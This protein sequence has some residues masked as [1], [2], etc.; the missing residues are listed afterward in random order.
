MKAANLIVFVAAGIVANWIASSH[1][2]AT[3]PSFLLVAE[4][5]DEN[6]R[7]VEGATVE[8]NFLAEEPPTDYIQVLSGSD[9]RA[10]LQGRAYDLGFLKVEK[11][12]YYD[13]TR[14]GT[15]LLRRAQDPQGMDVWMANSEVFHVELKTK[16]NPTPMYVHS[17]RIR[18]PDG[19][20][21]QELG[22]DLVA[23]DWVWP[24]GEGRVPDFLM[25][26]TI[27]GDSPDAV[28]WRIALRF[29]NADDG[30]LELGSPL[31]EDSAKYS[32][33]AL[34]SPKAAP[35]AGYS[36]TFVWSYPGDQGGYRN[37][38]K[39]YIF[40]VRTRSENGVVD[41]GMFGKMYEHPILVRRFKRLGQDLIPIEDVVSFRYHVNPDGTPNLEYD[42]SRN[43]MQGEIPLARP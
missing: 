37:T 12:G 2:S 32:G 20:T 13:W 8:F 3:D 42:P 31:N 4:V 17:E 35:A 14:R 1:C 15:K 33:S 16:G 28:R 25:S 22:Y 18:L 27:E 23:G 40:R 11:P 7:P 6:G 30:I 41:G 26:T 10:W 21:G 43:L 34:R 38:S 24:Y 36:R 29:S 9:G 5:H 19:T 39:I